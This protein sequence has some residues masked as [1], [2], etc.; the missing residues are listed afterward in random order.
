MGVALIVDLLKGNNEQL[1]ELAIEL[2]AKKDSAEKHLQ[3]LEVHTTALLRQPARVS[4]S[5]TAPAGHS[6]LSER[7][8]GGQNTASRPTIVPNRASSAFAA[9]TATA[10]AEPGFHSAVR[11]SRDESQPKR[12]MSPA[13]A[14]VAQSVAARMAAGSSMAQG[15]KVTAVAGAEFVPPPQMQQPEIVVPVPAFAAPAARSTSSNART[16]DESGTASAAS[17][18]PGLDGRCRFTEGIS[19]GVGRLFVERTARSPTSPA[20]RNGRRGTFDLARAP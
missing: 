7:P 3:V 10:T 2:K 15:K 12:E 4:A 16:T 20:P 9:E 5:A 1:R 17:D 13:V 18:N 11:K 14:A 8:A 6:L 19:I